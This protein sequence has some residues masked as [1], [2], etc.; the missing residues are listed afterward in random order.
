M[1]AKKRPKRACDEGGF[2]L[3]A[4][5]AIREA[6]VEARVERVRRQREMDEKCGRGS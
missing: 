2:L 4:R 5:I 3:W 6:E 1:E